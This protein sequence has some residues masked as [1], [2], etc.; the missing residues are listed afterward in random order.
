MTA[1][2]ATSASPIVSAPAVEAVRRG[3]RAAFSWASRPGSLNTARIGRPSAWAT[4]AANAG[5]SPLTPRNTSTAPTDTATRRGTVSRSPNRPMQQEHE[6]DGG[7]EPAPDQATAEAAGREL[8]AVPHGGHRWHLAGPEGG[9]QGG[10]EGDADAH[11]RREGDGAGAQLDRARRQAEPDRAEQPSQADG[12][13]HT[14]AQPDDGRED[15]DGERLGE[16][17]PGDLTAGGADGPQQGQ[18][19]HPLADDDLEHVVDQERGHEQGD[20]REGEQHVVEDAHDV[21]E[22]VG[23]LV[24][25]LGLGRHLDVRAQHGLQVVA[26]LLDVGPVGHVE[27][28]R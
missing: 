21:A 2:M 14:Q 27:R 13:Q 15:T 7:D 4:G 8:E 19:P 9:G 24:G 1:V 16:D 10:E 3:M 5:A 26:D 20:E 23:R 12:E 25:E 17:G 28:R 18:L 22:G 6:A 11:H